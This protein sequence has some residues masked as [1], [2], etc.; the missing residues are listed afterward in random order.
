MMRTPTLFLAITLALVCAPIAAAAGNDAALES[1]IHEFL[2]AASVN[3][4]AMH[5][6]FWSED[7]IYTSSS[8][9]RFGKQRILDGLANAVPGAE[10]PSYHAEAL[11]IQRIDE[12]AVVTFR[13]VA[14][15]PGDDRARYFNTGVFRLENDQWRAFIWQATRADP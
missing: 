5:E 2:A 11:T 13:L 7:L 10:T 12:V 3:D 14:V 1:L 6:R 8:G 4:R 9:E 15:G